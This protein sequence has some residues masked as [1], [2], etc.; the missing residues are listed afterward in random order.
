MNARTIQ[1][2]G[3][4]MRQIDMSD[5]RD[6]IIVNNA[7]IMGFADKGPIYDYSWVTT[8]SQFIKLYGKPQTEAEKY[9]YYAVMSVL[10]NGGTPVVS[11]MPYDNKQCKAYKGLAIRYS[12]IADNSK[13]KYAKGSNNS[14]NS[15]DDIKIYGWKDKPQV[16]QDYVHSISLVIVSGISWII[17]N[18]I[19]FFVLSSF[20]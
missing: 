20:I 7:Y 4:E 12:G 16:E 1:H 10:N 11:R 8:P 17:T 19:S 2:P 6:A 15:I 3:V 9:L 14:K 13:N 5:Y 18:G